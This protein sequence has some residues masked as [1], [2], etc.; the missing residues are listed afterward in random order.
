MLNDHLP[1]PG[2]F[3]GYEIL[4]VKGSSKARKAA[5]RIVRGEL[6]DIFYL[7][8]DSRGRVSGFY[9]MVEALGPM[10]EEL[11][12][13]TDQ[14][15]ELELRADSY[16]DFEALMLEQQRVASRIRNLLWRHRQMV[17]TD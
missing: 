8:F 11:R 15:S 7:D 1:G 9:T 13:V 6:A 2:D 14:I 12:Q 4:T 16:A 5:A 10:V 17:G 3:A